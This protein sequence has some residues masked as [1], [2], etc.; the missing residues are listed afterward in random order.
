MDAHMPVTHEEGDRYPLKPPNIMSNIFL[1]S[2][3]H[4]GHS[5]IITFKRE[6]GTPLRAFSTIDEHDEHII[7]CHNSVV[8]PQDKVYFLGDVANKRSIHKLARMNGAKVLIKGNHDDLPLNSYIPYFY[9]IRACHRLDGMLLAHIPVHAF[10]LYRWSHQIHGHLHDK[11][12]P[13]GSTYGT[14]TVIPDPR[15]INVSMEC[16]NYTPVS[17]EEIKASLK[18]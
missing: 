3:H 10:N 11:R 1:C 9:D 14:P 16:I 18:T 4:I 2:D 12:I 17:L 8:R 5:N 13:L 7:E 6:D 15:Y